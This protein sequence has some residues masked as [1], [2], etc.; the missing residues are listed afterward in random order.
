MCAMLRHL[1]EGTHAQLVTLVY[2]P[3]LSVVLLAVR[4][5]TPQTDR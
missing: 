3:C 2:I 4:D 5:T 1:H